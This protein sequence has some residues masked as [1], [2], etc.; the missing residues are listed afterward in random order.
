M[1]LR[2]THVYEIVLF[3][4][5]IIVLSHVFGVYATRIYVDSPDLTREVI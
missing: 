2:I 1:V 3:K 4:V 5:D